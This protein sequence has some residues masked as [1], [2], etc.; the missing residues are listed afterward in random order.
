MLA[1]MVAH[2][3]ALAQNAKPIFDGRL[4]LTPTKLSSSEEKLMKDKVV[5]AARKS[6]HERERDQECGTGF[7]ST[8]T[9]IAAGSFTKPKADQKAILYQ[10]CEVGHDMT[11]NGIAVIEN[12]QVV[13]H[14]VYEGGGDHAIGA[15]PDINGN[16]L[17]EILL[18]AGGTNQGIT[19][20]SISIIELGGTEVTQFGRTETLSDECGRA[21]DK[22]AKTKAY[23]ISV[24]AG[25]SPAFYRE[26]YSDSCEGSGTR[27]KVG[28]LTAISMDEDKVEYQLLK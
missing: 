8:P 27:K 2:R 16:G 26:V 14:V 11:L 7:A 24:K 6:W 15:L 22:N 10:Y 4:T 13:A 3:D 18:A 19:W 25:P 20:G 9:D 21:D 28:G 5:P 23:R 12:G 1:T 17:S